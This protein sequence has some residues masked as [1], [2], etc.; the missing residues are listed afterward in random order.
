M[1]ENSFAPETREF[2]VDQYKTILQDTIK[3]IKKI[4]LDTN[5]LNFVVEKNSVVWYID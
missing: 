1:A 3:S 4:K 5:S 2:F